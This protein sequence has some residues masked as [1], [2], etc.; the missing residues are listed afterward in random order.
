MSF[1]ISYISHSHTKRCGHS[2]NVDEEVVLA[3]IKSGFKTLCFTDH[4]PLPK[5]K[6]PG[7]RMDESLLDDYVSSIKSLKEKYK[8]Q[9]DIHIALEAE[10]FEKDHDFLLDYVKNRGIEY[11][12]VGQHEIIIKGQKHW[13]CDKN[14]K[15]KRIILRQYYRDIKAAVKIGH[16]KYIAHPDIF[17][18]PMQNFDKHTKK[19][20]EKIIKLANKYDVYLEFN[21]HGITFGKLGEF[22][23]P[24]PHFWK[25]VKDKYPNTKI[26]VGIDAHS[27][28]EIINTDLFDKGWAKIQ[29]LGLDVAIDYT[30]T[31]MKEG[32]K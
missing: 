1:P 23:Y 10:F 12:I 20:A 4:T 29:E 32:I 21:I 30:P 22:A 15:D 6:E 9:I 31:L 26:A 16:A 19:V 24:N 11:F 17:I 8:D 3:A 5:Y 18:V 25:L 14:I 27:I 28:D 2:N 13:L 7:T